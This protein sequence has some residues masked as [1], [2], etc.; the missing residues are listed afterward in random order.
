M[1]RKNRKTRASVAGF[2][3]RILYQKSFDLSSLLSTTAIFS[4]PTA[5]SSTARG[6][7]PSGLA[8]FIAGAVTALGK[9]QKSK[10]AGR[11]APHIGLKSAG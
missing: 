1:L 3:H 10:S 5:A 4:L 2:N 6:S 8:Q 9:G 7:C 11:E